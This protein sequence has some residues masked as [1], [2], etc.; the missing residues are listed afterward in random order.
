VHV[1]SHIF[2]VH[3]KFKTKLHLCNDDIVWCPI[4][5]TILQLVV[6]NFI[7]WLLNCK[8]ALGV[9]LTCSLFL[10]LKQPL[11]LGSCRRPVASNKLPLFGMYSYSSLPYLL[12]I[13]AKMHCNRMYSTCKVCAQHPS[14]YW[15]TCLKLCPNLHTL[16]TPLSGAILLVK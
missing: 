13:L 2:P 12:D 8:P 15:R 16:E 9:F 5:F 1:S 10:L 3:L 11:E 14:T 6:P 7:N 4:R